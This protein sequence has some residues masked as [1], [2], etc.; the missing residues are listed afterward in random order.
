M[1]AC[2]QGGLTACVDAQTDVRHCGDC[3]T[4]CARDEIC[5]AGNCRVY[6]APVGCTTCPCTTACDTAIGGSSACCTGINGVT[7]PMC[8]EGNE[9]CP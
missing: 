2:N 4:Q 6:A 1:T 7:S 3:F 5:Q 9:A 8:L